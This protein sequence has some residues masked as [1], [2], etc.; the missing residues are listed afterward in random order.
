MASAIKAFWFCF[1]ISCD[2]EGVC[3]VLKRGPHSTFPCPPCIPFVTEF[4][5]EGSTG[6]LLIEG[7]V[8]SIIMTTAAYRLHYLKTISVAI[9]VLNP[10]QLLQ[11]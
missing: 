1:A 4:S 9:N 2:G 10:L 5:T 7:G 8:A 11:P 3:L 6:D